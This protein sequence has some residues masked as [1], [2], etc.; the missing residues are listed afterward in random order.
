MTPKERFELHAVE[1]RLHTVKTSDGQYAARETREAWLAWQAAI[2]AELVDLQE[3]LRLL[4]AATDS[5]NEA[6]D[7]LKLRADRIKVL[8]SWLAHRIEWLKSEANKGGDWD[9]LRIKWEETTYV[10]EK[11]RGT[12]AAELAQL[13]N[14]AAE[15]PTKE[16][17]AL[18][19]RAM[20]KGA[21]Q[22]QEGAADAGRPATQ[23]CPSNRHESGGGTVGTPAGN[24]DSRETVDHTP[25]EEFRRPLSPNEG[26]GGVLEGTNRTTSGAIGQP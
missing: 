24:D 3:I 19:Q 15:K 8:E 9:Y 1:R 23:P 22:V 11:F 18:G 16:P 7:G 17:A 6:T 10:L 20:A 25:R 12:P 13:S 5:L 21:S 26:D 14:G 4:T 2:D